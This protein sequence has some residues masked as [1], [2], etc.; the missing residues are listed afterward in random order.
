MVALLDVN[1][2]IALLEPKHIHHDIA[3][4]WF[5]N[6][7]LGHWASCPLTQNGFI[8]IVSQRSYGY[9]MGTAAAAAA[10]AAFIAETD[11][12]F[13][14]DSV[15]LLD[16][17][18]CDASRLSSAG[19]LTDTYLLAL[20]KAKGGQLITLDARLSVSAVAGGRDSLTVLR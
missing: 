8:R 18:H 9:P 13:W 1:V 11:H 4:D 20:A 7:R 2:L 17:S 6:H 16:P 10:L 5:G 14:P 12:E 19:Q 15:S 3:H